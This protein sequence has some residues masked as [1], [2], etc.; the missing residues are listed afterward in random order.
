MIFCD[1][2]SREVNPGNILDSAEVLSSVE[3]VKEW[4]TAVTRESTKFTWLMVQN[5]Q[6][7]SYLQN[8]VNDQDPGIQFFL[9]SASYFPKNNFWFH[10]FSP[11]RKNFHEAGKLGVNHETRIKIL[12][13]QINGIKTGFRTWYSLSDSISIRHFSEI[14]H[15]PVPQLTF[16]THKEIIVAQCSAILR[17]DQRLLNMKLLSDCLQTVLREE[18]NRIIAALDENEDWVSLHGYDPCICVQDICMKMLEEISLN[19]ERY[20]MKNLQIE[21]PETQLFHITFQH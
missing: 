15:H 12:K 21:K 9:H 17:Q 19:K 4:V 18:K 10:H 5:I 7:P 8:D 2:F 6:V 20:I 16:A 3:Q 11:Y 13:T 14:E 1:V